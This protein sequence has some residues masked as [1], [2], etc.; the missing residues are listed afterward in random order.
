MNNMM[1]ML[2]CIH[3]PDRVS[4]AL[5]MI[6]MFGKGWGV[7]QLKTVANRNLGQIRNPEILICN[8]HR[9]DIC[10]MHHMLGYMLT[11]VKDLTN[12]P[13]CNQ[14]DHQRWMQLMASAESLRI[15]FLQ[16]SSFIK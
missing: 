1:I 3:L 15:F 16:K 10:H 8:Q 11:S 6:R 5:R 2:H 12:I 13:S 7:E 14:Q 4:N 9:H